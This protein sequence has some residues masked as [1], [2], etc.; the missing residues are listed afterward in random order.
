[1]IYLNNYYTD[2]MFLVAEVCVTYSSTIYQ[3][4]H[5]HKISKFPDFSLTNLHFSLLPIKHRK[6]KISTY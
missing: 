2:F 5:S 3:G 4:Y 1:M 6:N